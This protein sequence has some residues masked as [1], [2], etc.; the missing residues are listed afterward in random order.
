MYCTSNDHGLEELEVVHKNG[1]VR[2]L[3]AMPMKKESF[4]LVDSDWRRKETLEKVDYLR[5]LR[6]KILVHKIRYEEW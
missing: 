6:I 2:D 5:S 1:L 4:V 3:F